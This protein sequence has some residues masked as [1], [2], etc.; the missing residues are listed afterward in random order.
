M[1]MADRDRKVRLFV[2]VELPE[3]VKDALSRLQ[4]ELRESGVRARWTHTG[5]IHLTL[6]FLGST[7]VPLLDPI[8]AELADATARFSPITLHATGLSVFPGVKRAKVLWTGI[9]GDTEKLAMLHKRV[10]ENL[11]LQGFEKE[12][13]RF[14]AH[15]TLARFKDR[16]D[17]GVLVNAIERCGTFVTDPFVVDSVCLF[18]SNLTPKGP[19]YSCLQSHRLGGEA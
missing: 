4:A 2:A 3:F 6:K 14:T 16:V 11:L 8:A 19:V 10:E 9:S 15:L 18:E 5:N 7:P 13:R 1:G 12:D 17:P